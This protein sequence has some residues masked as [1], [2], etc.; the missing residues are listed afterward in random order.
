MYINVE[1]DSSR[2]NDG[3]VNKFKRLTNL[4]RETAENIKN[5][6]LREETEGSNE[7]TNYEQ[8]YVSNTVVY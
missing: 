4:G 3:Y 1:G 5:G 8:N 7:T 6:L 2:L